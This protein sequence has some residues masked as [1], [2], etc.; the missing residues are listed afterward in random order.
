MWSYI[1]KYVI[2]RYAAVGVA[3]M[4]YISIRQV[5]CSASTQSS[6]FVG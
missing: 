2:M 1:L 5:C 3:V 6:D 4:P